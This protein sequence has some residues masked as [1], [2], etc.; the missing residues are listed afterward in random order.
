[1]RNS[2]ERLG[3]VLIFCTHKVTSLDMMPKY[4]LELRVPSVGSITMKPSPLLQEGRKK[5][6]ITS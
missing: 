5:T 4:L 2:G 6:G 3:G 1:M